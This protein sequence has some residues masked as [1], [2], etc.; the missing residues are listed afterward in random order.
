MKRILYPWFLLGLVGPLSATN[1]L[2]Q[3]VG[4]WNGYAGVTGPFVTQG[5]VSNLGLEFSPGW[6]IYL[7]GVNAGYSQNWLSLK[8]IKDL[9][10]VD[11]LDDVDKQRLLNKLNGPFLLT[12]Q[13]DLYAPL[14]TAGKF[15]FSLGAHV[16]GYVKFPKDMFSLLLYGDSLNRLYDLSGLGTQML[17]YG[18]VASAFTFPIRVPDFLGVYPD[19]GRTLWLGLSLAYLHGMYYVQLE[20]TRGQFLVTT[21]VDAL[22]DTARFWTAGIPQPG[23]GNAAFQLSPAGVGMT[24]RISL[25]TQIDPRFGLSL[26]LDNPYGWINWYRDVRSGYAYFRLDNFQLS[27]VTDPTRAGQIVDSLIQDT[28]VEQWGG[29]LVTRLPVT[30]RVGL[31]YKDP[32][33]PLSAFMDYTQGFAQTAWTSKTPQVGFGLEYLP[34]FFWPLRAYVAFGGNVGWALGLGTGIQAGTFRLQLGYMSHRGVFT[35]AKGENVYLAIG[36]EAPPLGTVEG[37]IKD[38]LT[39]QPLIARIEVSGKKK[40]TLSTDSLGRFSF[41]GK[42]GQYH[43]VASHPDYASRDLL[44]QL[45]AGKTIKVQLALRPLI[46][47]VALTF[48]NRED[49]QPVLGARVT[50]LPEGRRDTVQLISDSS[51]QVTVRLREGRYRMI[52]THPDFQVLNTSLA[53]RGGVAIDRTVFLD[54]L[55]GWLKLKVVDAMKGTPLAAKVVLRKGTGEIL[56]DTVLSAS[57][58]GEFRLKE[59]VYRLDLTV[60]KTRYI[61]RQV[62][63]EIR[64]GQILE[65]EVGLLKKKMVFTFRNILFD[66]NKATLRPESYPVLDSIAQVLKENPTVVVEIGGHTDTRGSFRYNLRLSQARANSVR[67]YL[68]QKGIEPNRLVAKGYGEM[69]PL[70]K[71]ERTEADYQKN[72]RVEFRVLGEVK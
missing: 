27:D 63:V 17:A 11:T 18:E 7:L 52:V 53:V 33:T 39:G 12:T 5:F 3:A 8:E 59:G 10:T 64:G 45:K 50:L 71:P 41:K 29:T 58:Y 42:Q 6:S 22:L 51:G 32:H 36:N 69:R 54:P 1:P 55:Y 47:D 72:R 43:I 70:V 57:G 21:G 37:E 34:V 15:A 49:K 56:K 24:E 31:R 60:P 44:V 23:S 38:S 9:E 30:L 28:V 25:A 61:Q 19:E 65:K 14:F 66:F 2:P 68:I 48:K 46:A 16:L 13:T 20:D 67:E 4:L 40:L 26:S 62:R 35:S